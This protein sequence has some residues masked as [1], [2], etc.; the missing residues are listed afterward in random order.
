V[1]I[2]EKISISITIA[3]INLKFNDNNKNLPKKNFQNKHL[4]CCFG[5]LKK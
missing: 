2:S 1:S 3:K 4:K 5:N